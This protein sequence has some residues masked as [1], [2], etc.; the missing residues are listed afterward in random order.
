MDGSKHRAS[1]VQPTAPGQI[2]AGIGRRVATD[3]LVEGLFSGGMT[4]KCCAS[5]PA[6]ATWSF[7]GLPFGGARLSADRGTCTQSQ[8]HA[9]D[10][11]WRAE[12]VVDLFQRL[13][14]AAS[15]HSRGKD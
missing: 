2:A 5:G 10:P 11:K 8:K 6:S 4:A 13:R 14:I 15:D 1:V 12:P 3:Q 7:A 9:D